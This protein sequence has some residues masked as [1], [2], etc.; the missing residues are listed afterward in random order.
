MADTCKCGYCGYEGPV[1]GLATS[2]GLTAP[3]CPKC[4]KN[5]KLTPIE[6]KDRV[7]CSCT[8]YGQK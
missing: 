3:M 7:P 6:V 2:E 8:Q 5:N 4:G 1:Y